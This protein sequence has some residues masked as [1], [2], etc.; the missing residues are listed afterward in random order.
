MRPFESKAA[1]ELVAAD[2]DGVES[3]FSMFEVVERVSRRPVDSLHNDGIDNFASATARFPP[4]RHVRVSSC[5]PLH[6]LSGTKS[7][8]HSLSSSS[9]DT[10]ATTITEFDSRLQ[11]LQF[12]FD[13]RSHCV[14]NRREPRH[15]DEHGIMCPA[16]PACDPGG[17]CENERVVSLLRTL[18]GRGPMNIPIPVTI[19]D[20]WFRISNLPV[21]RQ[22]TVTGFATE[23]PR[24]PKVVCRRT[25]VLDEAGRK[26]VGS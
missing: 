18:S 13:L 25:Q 12:F 4:R 11:K 24:R 21:Q 22:R 5:L 1:R 2:D 17:P 6:L 15:V 10:R 9:P 8:F 23:Q 14:L 16:L 3:V 26:E 20:P 19:W 7:S